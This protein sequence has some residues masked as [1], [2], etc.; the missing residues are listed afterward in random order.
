MEPWLLRER[1]LKRYPHF[2]SFISA[3]DAFSLVTSAECVAKHKFFPFIRF[4]QRWNRF[5]EKNE[6]GKPKTRPIRYAARRDAYIFGYYRHL[7]SEK[8]ESKLKA[9]GLSESIIAYRRIPSSDGDGGKCNIHFA[10][11]VFHTIRKTGNC[12]AIALDISSYFESLDHQVLKNLWCRLL[13]CNR[14]PLDHYRVFERITKYAVVEKQKV[15]ERLGF[16]GPKRSTK[17]GKEINGYLVPYDKLPMQLC[18]AKNF[19]E[20]IAGEGSLV[21]IIEPNLNKYGIPQGA[22]ISDLLANLYLLDFDSTVLSWVQKINGYYF[23]YSDDILIILPGDENIGLEFMTRVASLIPKFGSKLEIKPEK[24]QVFAFERAGADQTFKWIH[25]EKGR[26]GLEYLGFRYDGRRVYIR[27]GTLSN[28]YRKITRA[29]RREAEIS[30]RRYPDKST[31]Q[32]MKLFNYEKLMKRSGRVEDFSDKQFD[33][34]NWTF[35]TY[36]T[37]A[38]QL[39]GPLGRPIIR[40]LRGH[41]DRVR[42]RANYE[43]ERAVQRREKRKNDP[44]KIF[45]SVSSS[46]D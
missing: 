32:L 38:A 29:A 15:Y 21:S 27:D 10:R 22:P 28:L 13:G 45:A 2:D 34:R 31:L 20:K 19:R 42:A 41:A 40:Q 25:G 43:L 7:L 3:E 24:S 46:L 14:L 37:R 44:A 11:D 26:N 12:V 5:A 17:T 30:A 6:K 39:F 36:A 33:K 16:F 35:W 23:R 4:T 9:L 8:Y 1:D 18:S